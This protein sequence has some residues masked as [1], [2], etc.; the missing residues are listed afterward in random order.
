MTS[1]DQQ[2]HYLLEEINNEVYNIHSS[3]SSKQA[4]IVSIMF[5]VISPNVPNKYL[6]NA[7]IKV[8]A[9]HEQS[10]YKQSKWVDISTLETKKQRKISLREKDKS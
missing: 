4:G 1:Y 10:Q 6:L 2:V 3:I 7:W 5:N 8:R 9:R